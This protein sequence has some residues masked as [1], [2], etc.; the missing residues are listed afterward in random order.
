MLRVARMPAGSGLL[1]L[2][3]TGLVAV[4]V[5]L[6]VSTADRPRGGTG[7]LA[8]PVESWGAPAPSRASPLAAR[9]P[10]LGLGR[11]STD[12]SAEVAGADESGAGSALKP[13]GARKEREFLA[14]FLALER[15]EPGALAERAEAVLA[16]GG[17]RAE[18][19]ALLRALEESGSKER[20]RWLEH[21]ARTQPDDSGPDGVSVAS[22][23][24]GELVA[25]SRAERAARP[26]LLRLAF[27]TRGL[28]P[29]LR[30]SAAVGYARNAD[31]LELDALRVPLARENDELLVA[32]VLAALGERTESPLA[33]RLLAAFAPHG[34]SA[35]SSPEE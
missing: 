30:R 11:P 12:G 33:A 29:A 32:G 24:I 27:E 31:D 13:P 2:A 9:Q 25:A 4:H 18:K 28:A 16:K 7:R 15:A 34:A 3:F 14:A 21:A 10:V 20:L 6:L 22:F 19:V 26:A 35:T 23:A 8:L 1:L 5:L 17:P